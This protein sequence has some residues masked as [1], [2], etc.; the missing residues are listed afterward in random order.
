MLA[1]SLVLA[2]ALLAGD[3]EPAPSFPLQQAAA[4]NDLHK[5]VRSLVGRWETDDQ[6]GD[7]SPDVVCEYRTTAGGSAVVETL[8]PG[9]PEEMVTIYHLDG[10]SIGVTHYCMMGN[11]PYLKSTG[12]STSAHIVF[13][14]AGG[15][16]ID[17]SAD[18]YMGSLVLEIGADGES[19]IQRWGHFKSGVQA[20]VM[21]FTYHR[22]H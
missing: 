6:D 19:L 14:C 20:G 18:D 15:A 10:E 13:E 16:N 1:A 7:G 11:Q 3:P 9:R 12:E 5:A 4:E 8:F 22:V 17:R 21:T 2:S